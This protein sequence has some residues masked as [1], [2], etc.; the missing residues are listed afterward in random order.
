MSEKR[1]STFDEAELNDLSVAELEVVRDRATVLIAEKAI[2][3][4]AALRG[5]IE[6]LLDEHGL[7]LVDVFEE[8]A[9]KRRGRRPAVATD[10]HGA[11]Q[12]NG[13]SKL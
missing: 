13:Q 9:P 12:P 5:D 4:K 1:E 6:D 3:E 8:L 2:A 10:D 7:K 11:V